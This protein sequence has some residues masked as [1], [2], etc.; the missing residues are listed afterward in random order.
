MN[1]F[2]CGLMLAAQGEETAF[3]CLEGNSGGGRC[4]ERQSLHQEDPLEKKMA[5]HSSILARKIPWIEEPWIQSLHLW[6]SGWAPGGQSGEWLSP[7][8]QQ[9]VSILKWNDLGHGFCVIL[10]HVRGY[11]LGSGVNSQ[12]LD[13]DTSLRSR[14]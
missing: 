13:N 10:T 8:G 9:G 4:L 2:P 7:A 12:N 1:T 11:I 6:P 5:T 3:L 14:R